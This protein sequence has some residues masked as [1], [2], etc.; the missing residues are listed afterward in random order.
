MKIFKN[1]IK[2]NQKKD[3]YFNIPIKK[4]VLTSMFLS[5]A[6]I[7]MF[8]EFYIP[9]FE[10][11]LKIDFS[12]VI[13]ILAIF[14]IGV[15]YALIIS[16][17]KT[18]LKFLMYPGQGGLAGHLIDNLLS[19]SLV[20]II[21]CTYIILSKL[22]TLKQSYIFYISLFI[23]LF[24]LP[25]F[26]VIFNYSFILKMYGFTDWSFVHTFEVFYPFTIVK[27]ALIFVIIILLRFGLKS[28][29]T[30][31]N[32]ILGNFETKFKIQMY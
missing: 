31:N 2:K 29:I 5:M 7:L 13:V 23:S 16:I 25:L 4:L 21:V 24:L 12:D 26:A 28:F 17:G 10:S 14:I 30:S 8:F 32:L 18:W 22:K 9:P 15:P 1:K 6:T 11:F 3:P 27:Y 20:L 19:T